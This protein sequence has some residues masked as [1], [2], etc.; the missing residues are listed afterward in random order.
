MVG[1]YYPVVPGTS[2]SPQYPV[3]KTQSPVSS[4]MSNKKTSTQHFLLPKTYM[5]Q[6]L[7][8]IYSVVTRD[9]WRKRALVQRGVVGEGTR[10]WFPRCGVPGSLPALV[11]TLCCTRVTGVYTVLYPGHCGVPRCTR[12]HTLCCNRVTGVYTVLC[13]GHCGVPRCT[14]VYTVL[15]TRVTLWCTQ[16]YKVWG[17]WVTGV[18]P[19]QRTVLSFKLLHWDHTLT[20]HSLV[21][22]H[23]TAL[24]LNFTAIF[25]KK[26]FLFLCKARSAQL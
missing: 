5:M 17:T 21:A 19:N 8:T 24:L 6:M 26:H 18:Y 4:T 9:W 16:V 14:Q 1:C 2:T 12:V 23:L 13:P 10:K 11:H 25:L 20:V 3:Y 22:L 15:C 7:V